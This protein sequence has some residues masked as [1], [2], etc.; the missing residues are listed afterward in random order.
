MELDIQ[1]D[2]NLRLS[3]R[4]ISGGILGSYRSRI[5]VTAYRLRRYG[6]TLPRGIIKYGGV[7]D[8]YPARSYLESDFEG[9][10]LT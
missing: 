2:F 3:A 1:G 9:W 5:G 10:R 8:T 6:P 4:L 7:L